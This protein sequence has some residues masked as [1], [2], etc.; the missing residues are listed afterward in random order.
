GALGVARGGR[1]LGRIEHDQVVAP[2]RIACAAQPLE[3]VAALPVDRRVALAVLARVAPAERER[4]V[5]REA[6]AVT[7]A[8]EHVA[9]GCE[10]AYERAVLTLVQIEAGLVAGRYVDRVA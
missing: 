2:A 10:A 8:V 6:A 4:V 9:S 7:E 5:E 3:H 1:E